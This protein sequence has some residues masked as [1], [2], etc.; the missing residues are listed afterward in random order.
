MFQA[1]DLYSIVGRENVQ[2]DEPLSKHTTFRIGGAASYFVTPA[3]IEDFVEAV[4]YVRKKEDRKSV[5]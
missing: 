5:V 2:C 3:Y 1:E 4:T